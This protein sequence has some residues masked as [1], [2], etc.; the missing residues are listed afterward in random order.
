MTPMRGRHDNR[1]MMRMRVVR[2]S[3][4]HG[5]VMRDRIRGRNVMTTSAVI[6][7]MRRRGMLRVMFNQ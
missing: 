6:G 2:G 1:M 7:G 5:V 4:D 3:V